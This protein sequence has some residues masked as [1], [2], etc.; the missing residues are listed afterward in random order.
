M[1]S[2]SKLIADSL[3]STLVQ[4]LFLIQSML[5]NLIPIMFVAEIACMV[6]ICLLYSLYAFE[7][8]WFNLGWELHRRLTFIENN[9]PYFIGFGMPLAILTQFT[10]SLYIR[11]V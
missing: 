3:F 9:W 2:L 1:S 7:Y 8:K 5:V 11:Y 4:T 10:S 6:H